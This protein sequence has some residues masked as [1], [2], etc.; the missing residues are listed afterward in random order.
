MSR[1]RK[2]GLGALVLCCGV[3]AIGLA[4][5]LADRINRQA[6]ALLI[7]DSPA[8][9]RLLFG[10]LHLLGNGEATNNLGVVYLRGLGVERDRRRAIELFED[11][12]EKGVV[13]ARYNLVL[14]LPNRNKTPDAVIER[15]LALL[16]RNVALGDIPSHVLAAERLYYVNRERFVPDRKA[17][18]LELLEVAAS[19]G[20]P[21]YIYQL[22]AELEVRAFVEEDAGMMTRALRAYRSAYDKGRIRGAEALGSARQLRD[23]D[24]VPSRAEVLE[25]TESEWTMI[26][27]EGGSI[28]AKCRHGLQRFRNGCS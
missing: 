2:L 17:R 6:I 24:T 15:Q 20:D 22:G 28:T 14:T 3:F 1:F 19:S 13:A 16:E 18:K 7:A 25:K 26:A 21:D 27:A 11:A 5:P 4:P 10:Y 8:M 23:W 12:V 9:A